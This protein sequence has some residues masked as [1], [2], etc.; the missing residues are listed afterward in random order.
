MS[1][2]PPDAAATKDRWALYRGLRPWQVILALLPIPLLLGGLLGG[3]IAA[4][5]LLTNLWVARRSLR[6]AVKAPVMVLIVLAAYLTY[7]V[8]IAILRPLFNR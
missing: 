6:P 4:L 7:G 8:C 5:A 3:A 2:L 1:L